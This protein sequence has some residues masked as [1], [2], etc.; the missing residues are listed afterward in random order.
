MDV[1]DFSVKYRGLITLAIGVPVAYLLART[2]GRVFSGSIDEVIVSQLGQNAFAAAVGFVVGFLPLFLLRRYPDMAGALIVSVVLYFV[3]LPGV[4]SGMSIPVGGIAF[5]VGIFL[6]L[7]AG[8]WLKRSTTHGSAKWADLEEIK[9][10]GL[11]GETG[12]MLGTFPL[13]NG[14]HTKLHYAGD[15]HSLTVAPTRTGKGVSSVIPNLLTYQGSAL[16][17]DPKGENAL[18]TAK[19]RR[20]LGQKV[21]LVDPWDLAAESGIKP[22]RFNPMDWISADDP[23][24]AENAMLLADALVVSSKGEGRF[25]DEEAKA[26]LMGLILY[27]GTHPHEEKERTLG[28][29]RDLL[30]ESKQGL[31]DLYERMLASSNPVV[32]SSCSR[33]IQKEERVF[34][35]VLASAQANT[36]FLDNHRIRDALSK[37]DFKFEDLKTGKITVYLILPADRLHTF[38]RWLRLLVQ[39]AITVNARNIAE[40]PD[41]PILFMLDELPALGFLTMVQ[42]GYSL[43]AGFGML[44]WGIVQDLSQLKAIYGDSWETFVGNS[45]VI[46]YFGSRDQMTAEYFSALCGKATI[47]TISSAISR[48]FGGQS[49]GSGSNTET[50]G[51]AQRPLIFPDELMRLHDTRQIVLVENMNPISATKVKWYTDPKLKSLGVNLHEQQRKKAVTRKPAGETLANLAM[52]ARQETKPKER[53]KTSD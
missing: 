11:T 2:N 8:K 14:E 39:Q 53:Q 16:V 12:L 26:L 5:M 21:F 9:A 13:E 22:A 31:N 33:M 32:R 45:G 15:R 4:G 6:A 1:R 40:K 37:S 3:F 46:Q 19:Q 10:K 48:N 28:R 7:G 38:G 27:V 20:K 44:L 29:V 18:E 35:N 41:Q 51:E 23:D 17:I 30:M 25:W 36:H 42:Q 24:A 47:W 34:S 50:T 49:G 52:P 43:M